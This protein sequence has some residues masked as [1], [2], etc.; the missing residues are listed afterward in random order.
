MIV[1]WD[2]EVPPEVKGKW[3]G[4]F[5]EMTALNNVQFERCLVP[6][7]AIGNPSCPKTSGTKETV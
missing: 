3:K 1:G 2:D 6:P 4:V 5:K 7:N